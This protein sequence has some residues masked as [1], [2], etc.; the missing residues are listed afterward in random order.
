MI[1]FFCFMPLFSL[2]LCFEADFHLAA[3]TPLISSVYLRRSLAFFAMLFRRCCFHAADAA[4]ASDAAAM[5]FY[6]ML[7][8]TPCRAILPRLIDA[9]AALMPI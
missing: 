8:L 1:T 6:E 9:A 7:R 5:L 3:D 4:A 2:R